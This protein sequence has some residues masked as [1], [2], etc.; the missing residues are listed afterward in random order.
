MEEIERK[1][2]ME[3]SLYEKKGQ[4]KFVEGD[5][6]PDLWDVTFY[7]HICDSN[8]GQC[9]FFRDHYFLSQYEEELNRFFREDHY[10]GI[11]PEGRDRYDGSIVVPCIIKC[12][13]YICPGSFGRP[14]KKY[15]I[16]CPNG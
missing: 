8:N 12:V 15:K 14:E 9:E 10:I 11:D 4:Y 3:E 1:E 16:C 6:Y 7:G 5:I 13:L 2:F